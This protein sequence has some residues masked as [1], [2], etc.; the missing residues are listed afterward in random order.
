MLPQGSQNF[1]I[2]PMKKFLSILF[3]SSLLLGCTPNIKEKKPKSPEQDSLVLLHSPKGDI[4]LRLFKETP[5]HRSNFL[6]LTESGY[7]DTSEFHR[8]IEHFMI[9][10]GGREKGE[11][12]AGY[13]VPAE[14]RKGIFHKRGVLAAAREGDDI[15]PEMASSASQFYIVQGR[16]YS[17]AELDSLAA[18]LN[19]TFSAEER[20]AY[21][22]IGGT[23][24][25]DQ[26]YTV[27]GEVIQGMNVVDSIAA[28]P[29]NKDGN[30][31]NTPMPISCE[32]ILEKQHN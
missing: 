3:L 4:L 10:G 16:V 20:T 2:K 15:N 19:K 8:I 25:L 9:Q 28:T 29:V 18:K 13:L 5:L 24:W 23:P 1:K 31:P 22:T 26:K 14:I 21:T 32:I 11:L 17:P 6:K 30:Y 27:F 7:F 12:D